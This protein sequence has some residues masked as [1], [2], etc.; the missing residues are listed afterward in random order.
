MS[1]ALIKIFL[2]LLIGASSN[3]A[4][5]SIGW[6]QEILFQSF[7]IAPG[8]EVM[9][10][11]DFDGDG[12]AELLL[13]AKLV[14][15][16]S[17][18][19][20]VVDYTA[21]GGYRVLWSTR[22]AGKA[23]TS[24]A[25]YHVAGAHFVVV[26]YT[27]GTV[28]RYQVRDL[29]RLDSVSSGLP[30]VND[31]AIGDANNDGINEILAL[32][33]SALAFLSL[34]QLSVQQQHPYGGDSIAVGQVDN[35]AANE[36]VI[37]NG[38]VLQ[39]DNTSLVVEWDNRANSA[40]SS[41]WV[42]L[43]LADI[44]ADNRD[45]IVGTWNNVVSTFDAEARSRKYQFNT[46]DG[47]IESLDIADID[48]NGT[49]E[50]LYGSSGSLQ[51]L[52]ASTG[53][54]ITAIG[55]GLDRLTIA[56]L[57]DDPASEIAS[58]SGLGSSAGDYLRIHDYDTRATEFRG[59]HLDP[60]LLA[61]GY[62]DVD[63]DGA[64]EIVFASP[65][66]GSGYDDG[67][68]Y[69]VDATTGAIEWNSGHDFFNGYA[70]TGL[71][72]I[73][74]GDV[75]DDGQTE[76][77]VATDRLYY[78]ALFVIDGATRTLENEY[79]YDFGSPMHSVTIGDVDADGD[80]EIITGGGSS[81]TTSPEP[82]VYVINGATGIVE[83]HSTNVGQPHSNIYH[84]EVANIDA[85]A[86]LEIIALNDSLY[87]FDGLTHTQQQSTQTDYSNFTYLP[88]EHSIL[89]V[90][91]QG[92]LYKVNPSNL[93][94]TY[95]GN[96]CNEAPTGLAVS[97]LGNLGDH[98]LYTCEGELFVSEF[99][100]LTTIW[101][102]GQ[103]SSFLWRDELLSSSLAFANSLDARPVDGNLQILTTTDIAVLRIRAG[104]VGTNQRVNLLLRARDTP[105]PAVIGQSVDYR[106]TIS[107]LS[108]DV[109][110]SVVLRV[111]YPAALSPQSATIDGRACDID[112]QITCEIGFLTDRHYA[113]FQMTAIA[114]QAGTYE[115]VFSVTSAQQET[116]EA[117]NR[118]VIS[119][120]IDSHVSSQRLMPLLSGNRWEFTYERWTVED[121]AVLVNGQPTI[122]VSRSGI[123]GIENDFF[124][125][126]T[127]GLKLHAEE[128]V[129]SFTNIKVEVQYDPPLQLTYGNIAPGD[130]IASSGSAKMYVENLS[131]GQ[132]NGPYHLT[133]V[134]NTRTLPWEKTELGNGT[135]NAL[136]LEM[137]IRIHGNIQGEPLDVTDL[138]TYWLA[139]DVGPIRYSVGLETDPDYVNTFLLSTSVDTDGDG[140]DVLIDNCPTVA[141]PNQSDN[142]FDGEGDLCDPD[143]DNDGMPNAYEKT[144][145][146]LNPLNPADAVLDFD[147]DGISN[148]DEY[149]AG[150]RPDKLAVLAIA[151]AGGSVTPTERFLDNGDMAEFTVTPAPDYLLTGVATTC[152]SVDS[153][154][155]LYSTGPITSD[156]ELT[157]IFT[158]VPPFVDPSE[159][160]DASGTLRFKRRWPR[161]RSPWLSPSSP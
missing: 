80:T 79:H 98:L 121:G 88:S 47:R 23:I 40:F 44:D 140:I 48:A 13:S 46:D 59:E 83:W 11:E 76:I 157:F 41:N 89:A 52:E 111:D 67:I 20:Y 30:E 57:D 33:D 106:A 110:S 142:D 15:S 81:F 148:V 70:V 151:G 100:T 95:Q 145:G 105:N 160:Q 69:I 92:D 85:D 134:L 141:N 120:Q 54:L 49:P 136:P 152:P 119:T 99:G 124:T 153:L 14:S 55:I 97:P 96:L 82:Y 108:F 107:N 4:T 114:G 12:R 50:I 21:T 122:K 143:N 93:T 7:G 129:A 94:R 16:N 90:D 9:L 26:G 28:E 127:G 123:D 125:N 72:D 133:Y 102:S 32:G 10:A 146:F 37:S 104:E 25:T 62:G 8:R 75:D 45:E 5:A 132:R 87:V 159:M 101:R 56:N 53:N 35:D 150:S 149:V 73:A 71:H 17:S 34:E 84:L 137:Q 117:N 61:I 65:V 130:A 27:D 155:D 42:R 43:R 147:N 68:V 135:A 128:E 138:L 115:T 78:G 74:I 18:Y 58:V 139:P 6:E 131:T 156:C 60:P 29:L 118:A 24:A 158:F 31:I 63:D 91:S 144:Y 113:Q 154:G 2:T 86:A 36:I 39:L 51:V 22:P 161:Q 66:S 38:L 1:R 19:L 109:A 116:T 77:V 103:T 3:T 112:D 64:P 126:D